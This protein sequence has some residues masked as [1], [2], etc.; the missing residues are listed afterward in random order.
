MKKKDRSACVIRPILFTLLGT[1]ILMCA[2]ACGG[3]GGGCE[4]STFV[5]QSTQSVTVSANSLSGIAFSSFTLAAG[6]S[7]KICGNDTDDIMA[8]VAWADGTTGNKGQTWSGWDGYFCI[9]SSHQIL[10]GMTE[11]E[12]S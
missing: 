3:G 8:D 4:G 2:Q 5:N 1:Y 7:N 6:A 9:T 10:T 11:D 12:C